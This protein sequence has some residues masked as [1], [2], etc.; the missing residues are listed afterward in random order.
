M[1]ISTNPIG[2]YAPSYVAKK[3]EVNNTVKVEEKNKEIIN[4]KEKQFFLNKYPQN[5]NEIFKTQ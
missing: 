4:D 2:N 5:K 3:P 1:N